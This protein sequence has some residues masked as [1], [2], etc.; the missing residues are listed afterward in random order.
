MGDLRFL[1][2]F[3]VFFFI[4]RV[5]N[6]AFSSA[7]SHLIS[8]LQG[9]F[10]LSLCPS[11]THCITFSYF[12]LLAQHEEAIH[13]AFAEEYNDDSSGGGPGDQ[14]DDDDD[15][16]LS[17]LEIILLCFV[18]VLFIALIILAVAFYRMR[19][20]YGFSMLLIDC[21]DLGKVKYQ[22]SI[23]GETG[24]YLQFFTYLCLDI[25]KPEFKQS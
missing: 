23:L 17:E 2:D 19:R 6:I 3:W 8:S 18:I 14:D 16:S 4:F 5:E 25:L 1:P 11:L 21:F 22:Q 10:L 12:R 9:F 24:Q 13:A 15:D 7:N 20:R